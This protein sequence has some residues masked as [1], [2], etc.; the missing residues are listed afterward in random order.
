MSQVYAVLHDGNRNFLIGVKN[1]RGYY[2]HNSSPASRERG[3]IKPSGQPLNGGGLY[4]LPGGHLEGGYTPA[5]GA[6]A[7]FLEEV[8]ED[9]AREKN[10]LNPDAYYGSDDYW[11]VYFQVTPI[12]LEDLWRRGQA[13]LVAG[14]AAANA[15]IA[16]R[17]DAHQY[18][19]LTRDFP[20]SPMDNELHE[21]VI[22]NLDRDWNVIEKWEK[23]RNLSWF[24][25]ILLNLKKYSLKGEPLGDHAPWLDAELSA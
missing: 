20:K 19:Q 15:V 8:N 24:Y 11:G 10:V 7:E 5:N 22:G 9:L 25:Y 12:L 4:A 1:G 18:A 23:D 16:H 21:C 6:L 2:F 3:E 14:V 13:N 17:Y